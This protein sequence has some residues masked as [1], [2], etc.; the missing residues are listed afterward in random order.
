MSEIRRP[1]GLFDDEDDELLFLEEGTDA[2][3]AEPVDDEPARG[4]G[5]LFSRERQEQDYLDAEP[6]PKEKGPGLLGRLFSV[7][8]RGKS[9]DVVSEAETM[10]RSEEPGLDFD[11]DLGLNEDSAIPEIPM[12]VVPELKA[13][14]PLKGDQALEDM[15]LDSMEETLEEEEEEEKTGFLDG[16]RARFKKQESAEEK[17]A[18]KRKSKMGGFSRV[19]II[20]L[21]VMGVMVVGVYALL[22]S[23]VLGSRSSTPGANTGDQGTNSDV[24]ITVHEGTPVS[25]DSIETPETPT[26]IPVTPTVE[27]EPSGPTPLPTAI[28]QVSTRFDLQIIENPNDVDLRLQRAQ[29]FMSLKAYSLAL[30]DFEYAQ[31]LV[32]ERSDVYL[33]LGQAFF[34]LRRWEEAESAF[35]T[36]VSFNQDLKEAHFGLGT[37]YYYQ[38]RYAEAFKEFDWAAEIDPTFIDAETWLSLTAY[39]LGDP[40]EAMGAAERAISVTLSLNER[41]PLVYV[42][43]GWAWSIQDIATPTLA[44][45]NAQG[46]LLY[47][48]DIAPYD[49]HV[50]NALAYFYAQYRPERMAEAEQLARF[51]KEWAE[52]D[53]EKAIALQTL[54]RIYL[55]EDRKLNA[56][57]PLSQASD[58]AK[59]DGK[60]ALAGLAE[61]LESTF[62]P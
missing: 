22:L 44:I 60:V 50:L 58:L 51:A 30:A 18:A 3:I 26:E 7:F 38:G 4:L 53:L 10:T 19:Q 8:R 52:T 35:G 20:V 59:A 34:E 47:A 9:A 39:Q 31:I 5:R 27:D 2:P 49:F 17:A 16:L 55:L 54:G 15:L 28:P 12:P 6:V 1:M 23:A 13:N 36:A 14:T 25:L 43:R 41:R 32:P 24:V 37:L 46:D 29:E 45:D 57:E 42:A 33:G 61:E 62:A 56:R 40:V 11:L 48:Y 21:A